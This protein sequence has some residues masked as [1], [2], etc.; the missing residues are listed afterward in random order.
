MEDVS[1]EGED[2]E[3][4]SEFL[5]QRLEAQ[6]VTSPCLPFLDPLPHELIRNARRNSGHNDPTS[7]KSKRESLFIR[8]SFERVQRESVASEA[9]LIDWEF[10]GR[11][12]S[13]Y[14]L[15]ASTERESPFLLLRNA[16]L[17]WW[18]Q[19]GNFLGQFRRGSL[20]RCEG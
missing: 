9:S 10:W 15:V 17:P 3:Q 16:S 12:M 7:P 11:V 1:L 4:G 20:W 19:R 2:E 18:V 5:L 13:D 6:Y 14:E 8:A